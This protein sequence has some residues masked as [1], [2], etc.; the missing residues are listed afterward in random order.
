MREYS[1]QGFEASH[2]DQRQ[3]WLKVSSHDQCGEVSSFYEE[4][5]ILLLNGL[6]VQCFFPQE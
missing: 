6:V 5:T 2:K 4:I 3:L 1:Q